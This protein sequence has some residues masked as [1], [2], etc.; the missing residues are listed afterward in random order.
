M[1]GN[2]SRTP[3]ILGAIW[4]IAGLLVALIWLL[5]RPNIEINWQ[6]ESEFESAGFNI[7]RG[8]AESGPFVQVNEILIPASS[9][10]AAGGVYAF[11]DDDVVAGQVYF[12]QLEDVELNG[13]VTRH[14]L[15][16]TE[17]P[18]RPHL[19]LV[20]GLVLVLVGLALAFSS[21]RGAGTK[22]LNESATDPA[23]D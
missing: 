17:A 9:D 8:L 22:V 15:V 13:S 7:L 19:L 23:T 3:V 5:Q 1:F 2:S 20:L 14:E 21:R 11:V 12:Y 16:S 6:T 18:G 10:A 4:V